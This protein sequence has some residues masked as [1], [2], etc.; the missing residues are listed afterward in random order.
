MKLRIK[1]NSI[2]F[3]LLRSEVKRLEA[4]GTIS[5]ET[6]FGTRTDQ[7]LKYSIAVSDGVDELSTEF[8]DNQILV[9]LPETEA[10]KWCRSDEVGI[11]NNIEIDGETTLSVLIEKDFECVGRPDDPDRAD[12]FPHP[13]ND[14]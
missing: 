3:R 13:A 14:R 1:G 11:E 9:L 2:R 5:E 8:S 6:R 10:L 4:A 12:A 7:T